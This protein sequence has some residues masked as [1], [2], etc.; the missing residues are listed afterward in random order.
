MNRRKFLYQSSMALAVTAGLPEAIRQSFQTNYPTIYKSELQYGF[1]DQLIY[2]IGI[3]HN[4]I[5]NLSL[6]KEEEKAIG[7]KVK[8]YDTASQANPTIGEFKYVITN[9]ELIDKDNKVWKI[10]TKAD[11]AQGNYAFPSSYPKDLG[12]LCILSTWVKITGK[13]NTVIASIPYIA[14]STNNNN[15]NDYY[16]GA[17]CFVTTA[18]VTFEG[19]PDNCEELT[20]LRFLRDHYIAKSA[21]GEQLIEQYKIVGPQI[22]ASINGLENKKDVY[23]YMYDNMILPSVSLI[24]NGYLKEATDYY[25]VFVKALKD[26]YC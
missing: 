6:A 18:C 12:F 15:N 19:K 22:V 24:K 26:K 13:N 21:E 8:Y 9:S 17:G 4:A 25:K 14:P 16:P 20:T 1:P 2:E 7:L 11:K 5:Q 10:T 23:K 3:Y